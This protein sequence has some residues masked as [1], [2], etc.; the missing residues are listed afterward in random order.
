MQAPEI[1]F[2]SVIYL[3][4]AV[5]GLFLIIALLDEKIGAHKANRYL[6]FFLMVFTLSLIDEF[7]FQSRFLKEYPQLI[8]LIWPLEFLYAPL[9]YF[10][11]RT[12]TSIEHSFEKKKTFL[13]FV[14]F[15]VGIVFALPTW[16]LD[17]G[18]KV[19]LLYGQSLTSEALFWATSCDMLATLLAALQITVY[20]WISF[21]YLRSHQKHIRQQFST[22]EDKNL[23]WLKML[24]WLLAALWMLHIIDMFFSHMLGIGDRAGELLFVLLVLF[25]YGMGYM[26]LRQPVIFQHN[27][28]LVDEAQEKYA[29]SKLSQEQN[30][31]IKRVLLH[32][33]ENNKP[34]LEGN[35]TLSGLAQEVGCSANHLSQVINSVFA[36]TFFDFINSYRIKEAKQLLLSE[37]STDMTILSVALES[38]FN[39]KSAFYTAFK[40]EVGM[41][42]TAYK[43]SHP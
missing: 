26:G 36:Q 4:G 10:Y 12:L 14:P 16:L 31:H 3:I 33:I 24:L 27:E 20:L 9:F 5:Q 8:G 43:K 38:G 17:N 32:V 13:H 28:L 42:P 18:Q 19:A 21:R 22:I 15:V 2:L 11:I 41:T 37:A 40:K 7:L 6:A 23:S 29:K 39:S 1:D 25:I 30:Q 34:Y 35:I